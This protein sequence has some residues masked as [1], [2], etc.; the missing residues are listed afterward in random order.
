MWD[1]VVMPASV[2]EAGLASA[3]AVEEAVAVA[4]LLEVELEGGSSPSK[5]RTGSR[6]SSTAS[7]CGVRAKSGAAVKSGSCATSVSAGKSLPVGNPGKPLVG[8]GSVGNGKSVPVVGKGIENEGKEK[9]G[10]S[11]GNGKPPV[12]VEIGS[13]VIGA[14]SGAVGIAGRYDDSTTMGSS[15][16]FTPRWTSGTEETTARVERATIKAKE[17]MF[18]RQEAKSGTENDRNKGLT[19]RAG[20]ER[21]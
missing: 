11:V 21:G 12:G 9:G 13:V 1:D 20:H 7:S 10:V 4:V 2:A 5:P 3:A 14:D 18:T 15:G 6:S 17:R 19:Y 8:N 16:S